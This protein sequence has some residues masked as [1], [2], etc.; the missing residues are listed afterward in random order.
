MNATTI[1]NELYLFLEGVKPTFLTTQSDGNYHELS[2]QFPHVSFL[3]STQTKKNII[4]FQNE[5]DKHHFLE[6]NKDIINKGFCQKPDTEMIGDALRYPPK[7]V[8]CFPILNKED[9]A[10]ISFHGIMFA[11]VKKDVLENIIWMENNYT[12]P[13]HLQTGVFVE[14]SVDKRIY[15][16]SN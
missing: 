6:K 13:S 9:Q 16:I 12:V 7:S 4:F 5:Q 15:K 10:F 1:S 8:A 3:F 11:S 14:Y 2:D